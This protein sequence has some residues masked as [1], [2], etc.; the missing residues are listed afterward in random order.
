MGGIGVPRK[1]ISFRSRFSLSLRP[2]SVRC[3]FTQR[4]G[5]LH[6]A[7]QSTTTNTSDMPPISLV[8]CFHDPAPLPL[9][10]ENLLGQIAAFHEMC[11]L[12]DVIGWGGILQML[13][14]PARR[15]FRN[16]GAAE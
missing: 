6:L 13:L 14:S 5:E 11:P 7:Q 2:N 9:D 4:L 1:G 16:R 10:I 3:L 8:M 12:S 15:F